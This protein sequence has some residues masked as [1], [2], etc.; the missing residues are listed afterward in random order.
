MRDRVRGW[1]VAAAVGLAVG[2]GGGG[3]EATLATPS[4]DLE[5]LEPTGQQVVFWYQHQ[6][7]RAKAL[8]E[9][10]DEFN[11]TNTHGITVRG[12]YAG[13]YGDIYNKMVVGLQGG[14][15]ADLVVAYQNQA[16]EYLLADGIVDLT[17]YMTSPRWGLS[18]A[19]RADYV[20]AF[21][22]QDNIRGQQIALPPNRSIEVLYY[23]ADWLGELGADGPPQTW[24]E[25]ARLCRAAREQPFSANTDS[26]RSVGF[27]LDED[28]S[29]MASMTYSRGGEFLDEAGSA[30]TLD[31]P[32]LAASMRLMQELIAEGAAELMGEDY[33]DQTAFNI[34]ESLFM[35][36]STSGLPFVRDGVAEGAGFAWDVAPPPHSTAEPVVNFY[37]ASVSVCKTTPERQLAAWLFLKWF[38]EPAQ[39]ARWVKASNYF[40]ARKSTRGLLA[41]Y[42]R[43]NP[44]YA[45]AY[46]LLD[47]G[48]PEPALAGYEGVRREISK[49]VVR[50]VQGA[51]VATTLKR[52]QREADAIL[53]DN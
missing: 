46:E 10:I 35:L 52:L 44:R 3:D 32:E 19:A 43:G 33:G 2:C 27:I 5:K 21:L 39:Q 9:M 14:S 50:V 13:G 41:D 1:L 28:A 8:L 49:A 17:P 47:Y 11:Q 16:L 37:G 45:H 18:A 24:D 53:D 23:N 40:P 12:E 51:D 38:T 15:V 34:G 7:A 30:Y 6:R 42:M 20:S 22:G 48:K 25:F 31:T 26:D 36:R 4:V 29:R